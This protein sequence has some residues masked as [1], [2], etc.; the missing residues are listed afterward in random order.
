MLIRDVVYI[1][2]KAVKACGTLRVVF[3]EEVARP[4]E[5]FSFGREHG[6]GIQ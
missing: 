2:A 4:V 6:V 5:T 1:S 3:S